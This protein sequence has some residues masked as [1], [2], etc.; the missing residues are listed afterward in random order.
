[1]TPEAKRR[2]NQ[3]YY[4]KKREEI[5]AQKK[6]YYE[7]NRDA[8]AQRNAQG[9][10]ERRAYNRQYQAENRDE[11]SARRRRERLEKPEEAKAYAKGYHASNREQRLAYARD[12]NLRNKEKVAERKQRHREQKP[13]L[14]AA[15]AMKRQARKLKA[16]PLWADH[17]KIKAFYAVAARLT[18][19][20]GVKHEVDHIVPLQS[21]IVCG[22]HCEANL[23]I[24]TK[25]ENAAK[26][27]RFDPDELAA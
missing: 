5:L 2:Y 8:I 26:H 17:E 18:R 15:Q 10:D 25:A 23:Q 27:N 14:Y 1:M 6:G 13:Y 3:A 12:W 22:L 19:E 21:K 4:E 24:L 7:A 16:T 9:A 11:I 20:T